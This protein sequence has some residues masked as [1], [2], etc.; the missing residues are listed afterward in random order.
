MMK[1]ELLRYLSVLALLLLSGAIKIKKVICIISCPLD[2]AMW[3]PGKAGG[4]G[5]C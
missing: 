3:Q 2:G 1:K 5:C 4:A